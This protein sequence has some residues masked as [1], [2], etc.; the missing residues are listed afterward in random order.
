MD[1][2]QKCG[3]RMQLLT[4]S[5]GVAEFYCP[6]CHQSYPWDGSRSVK[7]QAEGQPRQVWP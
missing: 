3:E 2:C 6:K 4:P 5:D 1:E 7:D